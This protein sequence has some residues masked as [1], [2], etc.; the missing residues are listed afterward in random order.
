MKE[1]VV[2]A[3]VIIFFVAVFFVGFLIE[4][5]IDITLWSYRTMLYLA[6]FIIIILVIGTFIYTYRKY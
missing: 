4:G 5:T 1:L 2:S 6:I 3:V